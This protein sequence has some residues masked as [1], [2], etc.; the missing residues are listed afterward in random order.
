MMASSL[1]PLPR[2]YSDSNHGTALFFNYLE[3]C[4]NDIRDLKTRLTDIGW[5]CRVVEVKKI[6]DFRREWQKNREDV[7]GTILVFFFGYGYERQL[8]IGS[9]VEESLF[10]PVLY[11]QLNKYK[12][13][14]EALILFT[15]TCFKQPA[16]NV[17]EHC[18]RDRDNSISDIFHMVIQVNGNCEEGSLMTR[19]LLH[20]MEN[21]PYNFSNMARNLSWKINDYRKWKEDKYYCFWRCTGTVNDVTVPRLWTDG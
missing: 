20:E 10:W 11:E 13:K 19:I 4:E 8:F 7:A 18:E 9:S 2:K 16:N 21:S 1:S 6:K 12:K 5:K 3:G 15:N 17:Y 14:H